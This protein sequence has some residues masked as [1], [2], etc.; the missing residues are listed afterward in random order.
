[1]PSIAK[2]DTS[3]VSP[4][5]W[6]APLSWTEFRA[7]TEIFMKCQHTVQHLDVRIFDTSK[8][9]SKE[10]IFTDE[11]LREYMCVYFMRDFIQELRLYPVKTGFQCEFT[12]YY[13][14]IHSSFALTKPRLYLQMST[15]NLFCQAGCVCYNEAS[16]QWVS[17]QLYLSLCSVRFTFIT[18][19]IVVNVFL[20]LLCMLPF[21][22]II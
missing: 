16:F 17:W 12:V 19:C 11:S 3:E 15:V 21:I 14:L 6:G 2:I 18:S 13:S 8:Q 4:T 1:M 5:W 9:E 10:S 20:H 22:V 7:S